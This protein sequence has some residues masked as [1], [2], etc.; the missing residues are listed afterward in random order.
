MPAHIIESADVTGFRARYD[1]AFVADFVQEIISAVW[2]LFCSS[3]TNPMIVENLLSFFAKNL[4]GS[5]ILAGQSHR[6]I[7]GPFRH[8]FLLGLN[9]KNNKR[10]IYLS[11]NFETVFHN[12]KQLKKARSKKIYQGTQAVRRAISILK[13][14]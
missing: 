7:C 11:I 1:D 12:M 14:F 10:V 6:S 5:V 8:S 2:N 4:L 3:G 9:P 13:T